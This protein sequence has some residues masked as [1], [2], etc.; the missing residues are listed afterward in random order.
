MDIFIA[1]IVDFEKENEI[2]CTLTVFDLNFHEDFPN[3]KSS[4]EFKIQVV[5]INDN[6]PQFETRVFNFEIPENALKGQLI[7]TLHA[8]DLDIS[9]EILY[10]IEQN[11]HLAIDEIS[12]ELTISNLFDYERGFHILTNN[13]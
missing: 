5:D 2:I 11:D 8:F 6:V 9:D 4:E 3:Q 10:Y 12:G 7:N 1:E 13:V